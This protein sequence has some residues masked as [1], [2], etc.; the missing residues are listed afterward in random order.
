MS[1]LEALLLDP[2]RIDIWVAMRTDNSA[3]SG[4]QMDPYNWGSITQFDT[5]LN[6]FAINTCVHLGPG[7]FQT[8][9]YYDGLT[10]S[11]WQTKTGQRI[12]GCGIDLTTL[13]LV[14]TAATT[15]RVYAIARALSGSTVDFFEVS[16]LTI[17]CNYVPT[18][19]TS[20][21][22]GAV[23]IMGNHSRV[24]RV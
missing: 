15:Q 1:L 18:Q 6:G 20:W 2:P 9:G 12:V 5:L 8:A 10:G 3:G 17:D 4:T 23:R 22:A 14:N 13:K 7:E 21:T 24:V 16:D 11:G 19:G